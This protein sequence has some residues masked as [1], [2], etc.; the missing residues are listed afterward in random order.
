M[1]YNWEDFFQHIDISSRVLFP[2]ITTQSAFPDAE[3][4]PQATTDPPLNSLF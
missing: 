4:A 2:S 3:K 1:I